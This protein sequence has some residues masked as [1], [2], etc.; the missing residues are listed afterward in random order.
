LTHTTIPYPL[1]LTNKTC[2]LIPIAKPWYI[3][4][5][6]EINYNPIE[7]NYCVK[8]EYN[9]RDSPTLNGY[10]V[11]VDNLARDADGNE[12]GG[13]LCAFQTG[14]SG[15]DLSKIKVAPCILPK[16]FAGP[17]WVIAYD[18]DEGYALISGGQ[19]T[20]DTGNGCKTGDGTNNS[21]LWIF[22]RTPSRDEAK[23]QMIRGIAEEAGFDLSVL[24]DVDHSDCG[25]IPTEVP[26]VSPTVSAKPTVSP[27]I[28]SMPTISFVPTSSPSASPTVVPTYLRTASPTGAEETCVDDEDGFNVWW[29]GT[30]DCD[31][32]EDHRW[33]RCC[34]YG[35][36][37]PQTCGKC[38]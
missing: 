3:H 10:T 34:F 4:Q 28:S 32:V 36:K 24:N 14:D 20:I 12:F 31:W 33:W 2:K 25:Y 16:L 5:Q 15:T 8:A 37:C 30:K 6:A 17:Y 22:L 35:N 9:I 19:P 13:R 26:S 1:P 29:G 7:Q 23:I 38:D 21:G 27:T 18:E 11:D